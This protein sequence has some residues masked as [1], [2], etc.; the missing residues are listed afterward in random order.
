MRGRYHWVFSLANVLYLEIGY[1]LLC[2]APR[3]FRRFGGG[4]TTTSEH[5]A[6]LILGNRLILNTS[7]QLGSC[8]IGTLHLPRSVIMNNLQIHLF[9]SPTLIYNDEPLTGFVSSKAVALL[10]YLV[11]TNRP[12]GRDVLATLFWADAPDPR[13]RKNLRDVLSN[14]RKLL[15]PYLDITR[16]AVG[17]KS[18][19]DS[20]ELLFTA[21]TIEFAELLTALQGEPISSPARTA[22]LEQALTLLQ[23]EFLEGFYVAEAPAFEEWLR[24]ERE[25]YGQLTLQIL[26][27]LIADCAQRGAHLDGINYATRRLALDPLEEETHRQLMSIHAAMGHYAAAL[28]QYERCCEIL[29]E[30][31]GTDPSPETTE[32][33]ERIQAVQEQ[34]VRHLPAE[35][36]QTPFVG[37]TYELAEI[38]RLLTNIDCRL[39][40][41]AGLGGVGKTRL[42]YQVARLC[43]RQFLDGV[44]FIS[45]ESHGNAEQLA[46]IIADAVGLSL[47]GGEAVEEQ[48]LNFLRR[49]ELLL[50]LDNSEVLVS[51]A[52]GAMAGSPTDPTLQP[53]ILLTTITRTAPAVKVLVTSRK[54]LN[55]RIEQI[56]EVTGLAVPSLEADDVGEQHVSTQDILQHDAVQLFLQCSQRVWA[57]A[58]PREAEIDPN[59]L[60]VIARICHLVGGMPLAIE[61][62]AGWVQTLSH[63][64]ILQEIEQGIDLLATSMHDVPT[65]HRSLRAVFDHSWYLLSLSEQAVFQQLSVFR[66]GFSRRAAQEVAGATLAILM[67]LVRHSFL[68][69]TETGHY[70]IHGLLRQYAEEQLQ[71]DREQLMATQARHCHCYA[72]LLQQQQDALETEQFAIFAEHLFPEMENLRVAYE[73]AIQQKRF[74]FIAQMVDSLYALYRLR[75]WFREGGERFQ[76]G[77]AMARK[78]VSSATDTTASAEMIAGKLGARWGIFCASLGQYELAQEQLTLGL[79]VA[80]ESDD[81]VETAFCLLGLATVALGQAA[82]RDAEV[83]AAESLQ[84][85]ELAEYDVERARALYCLGE[86]RLFL[87]NSEI[88]RQDLIIALN[89]AQTHQLRWTEADCV[90]ALG[91]VCWNQGDYPG[92]HRY[93]ERAARLFR[94]PPITNYLGVANA[95]NQLGFVAWSQGN[96]DAA[97]DY[98]E[99]AYQTLRRLGNRQGEGNTLSHLGRVAE[100]QQRFAEA[101]RLYQQALAI[102]QEIGDRQGEAISYC[103]LAFVAYHQGDFAAAASEFVHCRD[104]CRQIHFRRY[105][106]MALACLGLLNCFY[107]DYREGETVIRTSLQ[108]AQ[109]IQDPTIL[110]YCWTHLGYA[111]VGR[112]EW[113][114]ATKAYRNA[115]ELR[116]AAGDEGRT[117]DALSGLV[118]I[119]LQQGK[120]DELQRY[121]TALLTHL[122]EGTLA[123]ALL[124]LQIH[125][126]CYCAL[127]AQQ[128]VQATAYLHTAH[129]LL[130]QRLACIREED[131]RSHFLAHTKIHAEI[132]ARMIDGS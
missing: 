125:Y 55:L 39:L 123:S 30:E 17:I 26:S 103:N 114:E 31:L 15:A 72:Q 128:D 105:E 127:D 121:T 48:L 10:Y 97:A 9:G 92:A 57:N 54:R 60:L 91:E 110:G 96:L 78:V 1:V 11:A 22:Q 59:E 29:Y 44:Y 52:E 79:T 32:L 101:T 18:N 117:L 13:A 108:I 85:Y 109:E 36:E 107:N 5:C 56:F 87:G 93:F 7:S 65:R 21:D 130:Q 53:L 88:A 25:H 84:L 35:E 61:L 38:Q 63:A 16:Q 46:T 58:Q 68:Q 95:F 51:L 43:A 42:A 102:N 67:N 86:A 115:V 98:H 77:A 106:A 118:Y 113:A 129:A 119:A 62:A 41:L 69:R 66:G 124:P 71:A 64:E 126:V 90:A 50:V 131:V 116:R 6:L 8:G 70:H 75:S 24:E 2:E 37:R 73:W 19:L 28:T 3:G 34:P 122:D 82:Y 45:L 74:D 49:K 27:D 20:E 14:L 12:H 120:P 40:T 112:R 94:I 80:R 76:L 132:L 23:G 89:L 100:R 99:R 81:A 4:L 47:S 104:V 111:L 83:A 33:F